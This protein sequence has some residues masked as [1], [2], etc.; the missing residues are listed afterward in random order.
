MILYTENTAYKN[1][2]IQTSISP[3]LTFVD[4]AKALE[5]Y[6]KAF[7]AKETYKLETPGGGLVAKL[8]VDGAE[9]W[10]SSGGNPG[11]EI[12][13]GDT[14]RIILTTPHPELLF[15]NAIRAGAKQVFPV[16]EGHGWKLGRVVDPFGLHW[17]MG[18][19]LDTRE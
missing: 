12:V 11:R 19:P 16:G 3:W 6:K 18:Y 17:E 2:P 15:E 14:V 1:M 8:S 10:L 9:F 5:F 13:G 4:C 7:G